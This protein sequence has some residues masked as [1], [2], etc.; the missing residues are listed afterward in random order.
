M[1]EEHSNIQKFLLILT[2]RKGRN[3]IVGTDTQRGFTRAG[4]DKA[5]ARIDGHLPTGWRAKIEE[6]T[7]ISEMLAPG[8]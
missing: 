8:T 7:P 6:V 3:W 2:D 5:Y 4:V 1:N